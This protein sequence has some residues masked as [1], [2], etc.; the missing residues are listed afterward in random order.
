MNWV[1]HRF[2]GRADTS[3]RKTAVGLGVLGMLIVG[4]AFLWKQGV[5]V[6]PAVQT[7]IA[8]AE[9]TRD[10][11]TPA[12]PKSRTVLGLNV[13]QP[14]YY[15][16]DR[17]LM[18]LAQ[19]DEWQVARSGIAGWSA[20]DKT[21]IDKFGNVVSLQPGESANMVLVPPE[22]AFQRDTTRIRCVWS[23]HG[24][25]RPGGAFS[26]FAENRNSFEFDWQAAQPAPQPVRVW[27][28]LT[29][30]DPAD[31]VRSIDCREANA[32]P[33][34]TFSPKFLEFLKGYGVLRFM[35]WQNSNANAKTNWET[36]TQLK[37]QSQIGPQGVA[38]EHMVALANE[39][40]TDAWFSMPWNA[41]DGYVRLFATYVRDH[42]K[43]DHKV[44]VE[45]GNEVWNPGF[46]VSRQSEAE[47]LSEGLSSNPYEARLRRYAEKSTSVLKI[48][49]EV[50]KDS[51]SRLVRV[52]ATQHVSPWSAETVLG[53]KD[54]A[55]YVDALATA[56]YFGHDTFSADRTA[57]TG[58]DSVFAF[59]GASVATTIDQAVTNR[60]V[61]AKF[62]KRYIAYEAGQHVTN[63]NNV[64]LLVSIN[65]DPRMYGLYKKFI[66]DWNAKVGDTLTLFSST[67]PIS[68][69][70]AWG[71]REY[72]G[73]PLAETPKRKAVE[74]FMSSVY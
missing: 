69:Y 12:A 4:L 29:Q 59:L 57:I 37:S 35:G 33:T 14:L 66:A 58:L 68:R 19:G 44:Y 24:R 3:M 54:T 49:T 72:T 28:A 39:A 48:W 74:D 13:G 70:G 26:S 40:G 43:P 67:N 47:G 65:R 50:F 60:N 36:R 38:L 25:L 32:S 46:S 52:V 42:L 1:A 31:P 9:S 2:V 18:N 17:A 64:A 23:G 41:D 51:P 56:P 16:Q 73:Q 30:T 5:F 6:Q 22:G 15:S 10:Q 71:L 8:F 20:F 11:P 27:V 7:P 61:A 62:G 21:R 63:G 53:F 34:A 55:R 45:L